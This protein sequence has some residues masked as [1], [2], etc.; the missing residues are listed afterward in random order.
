MSG[1]VLSREDDTDRSTLHSPREAFGSRCARSDDPFER[2]LPVMPGAGRGRLSEVLAG[3]VETD[4]WTGL[5]VQFFVKRKDCFHS[6][7][8]LRVFLGWNE[9]VLRAVWLQVVFFRRCRTASSEIESNSISSSVTRR[10]A[11]SA[12]VQRVLPS[13]GSE[14]ARAIRWASARPSTFGV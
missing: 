8:E 14:Q 11:R 10:S 6:V 3:L 9:P 5:V 2:P 7:D 4:D 1:D 12:Y 13:G